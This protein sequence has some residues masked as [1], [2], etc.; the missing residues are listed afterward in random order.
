MTNVVTNAIQTSAPPALAV[1]NAVT[2]AVAEMTNAA[3]G[4]VSTA[5]TNTPQIGVTNAVAEITN[6]VV[7][8]AGAA[9][10]NVPAQ[11]NWNTILGFV[12]GALFTGIV[13]YVNTSLV[14]RKRRRQQ[15]DGTLAAIS[16]ELKA[17]GELYDQSSG[18]LLQDCIEK[19]EK[20]YPHKFHLKRS[21]FVV[22]PGNTGV[23]GQVEDSALADLVVSTYIAGN[24]LIE[25]FE[26][27]NVLLDQ[28]RELDGKVRQNSG[29]VAL[30]QQLNASLNA[31]VSHCD[32]LKAAHIHLKKQ[33]P[34]LLGRI[35][36]YRAAHPVRLFF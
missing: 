15:V 26:I 19:G 7:K 24:G 18:K 31:L 16:A 36:R 11:I 21:Y 17:L 28:V 30:Q 13:S 5:A 22:F 33:T 12:L 8:T 25:Q 2:N 27:N 29:N 1:S 4:A 6:A 32:V 23:V 3:A 20:I 14:E 9:A 35:E 34:E 10:S